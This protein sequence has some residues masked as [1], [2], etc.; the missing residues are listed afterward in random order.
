MLATNP[1]AVLAPDEA[2]SIM[3]RA[4]LKNIYQMSDKVNVR[5]PCDH[6]SHHKRC[7]PFD[8]SQCV[9][10]NSLLFSFWIKQF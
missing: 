10:A 8:N 9:I 6:C 3:L 1:I 4:S 5:F 2:A 7:V